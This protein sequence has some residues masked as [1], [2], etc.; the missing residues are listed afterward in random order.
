V[1]VTVLLEPLPAGMGAPEVV[2]VSWNVN[3]A[4]DGGLPV[5]TLLTVAAPAATDLGVYEWL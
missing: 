2:D 5:T 4:G 1:I 3:V